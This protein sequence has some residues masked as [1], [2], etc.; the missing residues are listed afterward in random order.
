[1]SKLRILL[2]IGM[3]KAGSTALQH[4]FRA[5]A[6]QLRA[7]GVLY[8]DVASSQVSH[9]FLT[10]ALCEDHELPGHFRNLHGGSAE[11]RA[12]WLRE[13]W[14]RIRSQVARHRPHTLLL[15]TE[16]LFDGFTRG[17][18][19]ALRDLLAELSDDIEVIAYVRRPSAYYLSLTQQMLKGSAAMSPPAPVGYREVLAQC[20]QV[21]TRLSVVAFER[22]QLSGGDIVPD[23]FERFLP[24]LKALAV[25]RKGARNETFSA[26]SMAIVQD[27]RQLHHGGRNR[28]K[29]LDVK[30]LLTGVRLAELASGWSV[31]PR[32]LPEVEHYLD[33]ASIDLLWLR[34]R[35]GLVFSGVDYAVVG[36]QPAHYAAARRV[37]DI[38]MVDV[39]RRQ[40]L[41]LFLLSMLLKTRMPLPFSVL[42]WLHGPGTGW[43]VGLARRVMGLSVP[44]PDGTRSVARS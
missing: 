18:G 7:A 13:D 26:E 2:H 22:E 30:R 21:F 28:Q 40:A 12:R 16:H 41:Q 23:F 8:P 36:E 14:A 27:Y 15:S 32:L 3:P 38:C 5:L 9:K 43:L 29:P 4:A 11:R 24:D 33:H 10:F 19:A 1:M 34:E 39:E 35:H 25:S 20:E 31:R 37:S 17:R 44:G 6:P 42:A